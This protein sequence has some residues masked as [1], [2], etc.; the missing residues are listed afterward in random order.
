MGTLQG[1]ATGLIPPDP[2]WSTDGSLGEEDI[3]DTSVKAVQDRFLFLLRKVVFNFGQLNDVALVR[4]QHEKS[5]TQL[6]L[7][8]V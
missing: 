4:A 8:F 1:C 7:V 5:T 3:V 2:V 6:I